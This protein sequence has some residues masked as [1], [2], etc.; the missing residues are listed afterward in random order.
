MGDHWNQ[1]YDRREFRR[2][3]AEGTV[4]IN[5]YGAW[6]SCSVIDISGGGG[7][8]QSSIRPQIGTNVLLQMRGLG[9]IRAKVVRRSKEDFSLQFDLD[10]YDSD[11][12]VD[13]LSLPFNRELF[14]EESEAEDAELDQEVARRTSRTDK[15]AGGDTPADA[16]H[17]E[18]SKQ[19][20][21][22]PAKSSD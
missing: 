19:P 17:D 14:P 2:L 20:L 16:A 13:N 10:D 22:P 21:T 1:I 4:R 12:L 15:G 5:F 8:F 6:Y 7:R 3:A 9:T 11:A 18:P